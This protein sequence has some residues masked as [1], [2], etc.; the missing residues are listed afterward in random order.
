MQCVICFPFCRSAVSF[1]VSQ[2]GRIPRIASIPNFHGRSIRSDLIRCRSL[3][4]EI[5]SRG[6]FVPEEPFLSARV[7]SPANF[8][9]APV[10]SRSRKSGNDDGAM[11]RCR[12]INSRPWELG[13]TVL[14]RFASHP[15]TQR[16]REMA[17]AD[18]TAAIELI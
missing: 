2:R 1:G 11:L 7:L 17:Q 4:V 3:G 14:P 9:P 10:I 5:A 8:S 6:H 16:Q 12:A 15:T 13:E 18:E